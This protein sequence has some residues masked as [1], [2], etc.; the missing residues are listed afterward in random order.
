M[1]TVYVAE[2]TLL[3]R[4]V[5]I[6]SLKLAAAPGQ[7]HFRTRFLREARAASLLNH[8]HIATVHDY[9]VPPLRERREDIPYSHTFSWRSTARS[10]SDLSA[11]SRPRHATVWWPTTGPAMFAKME[12]AIERAVVLGN[13][14][15]IVPDDLPES[16]MATSPAPQNLPT[17]HEAVNEMKKKFLI[18]AIEQANGNYT[19]AARILGIHSTNLHRLIRTLGLRAAIGGTDSQERR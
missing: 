12:N 8:P 19:E 11:A 2:D 6:K 7:R 15:M 17:Y 10:A 9:G 3:G 18:Q 5:A 13:T 1:G 16:L 4:R 14:E